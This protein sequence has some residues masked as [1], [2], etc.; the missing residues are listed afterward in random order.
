MTDPRTP[1]LDL[2]NCD[3]EPIQ[4]LGHV[5]PYGCLIAVSSDWNVLHASANTGAML[6]L[7][8]EAIIGSR[9]IDLLPHEVVH[10]LRGR[11]QVLGQDA[12]G[13]RIYGVDLFEDGRRFDVSVHQTDRCYLFEF[14][15]KMPQPHRDEMSLVAPLMARVRRKTDITGMAREAARAMKMLSGFDRVMVYRFEPDDS[16]TVIAEAKEAGMQPYM[17]LRFPAS[18]IPP[19]ARALYTRNLLRLIMDVDA[20]PQ[21]ILPPL[22]PAGKP[23]DLSMSVTRAVSPIHLQYLRNMGVAASMSV[24]ILREGRLWG[25]FACHHDTPRYI[26]Y[27]KRSAVELFAQLFAYE[28][29]A[30]ESGAERAQVARAR[31]LHELLSSQMVGSDAISE[32]FDTI[33]E[34]IA[35][36]IPFDGLAMW[37]SGRYHRAG[38]T[39]TPEEFDGLLKHLNTTDAGRVYTTERLSDGYRGAAAIADRVAGIMALP[40]SRGARDYIVLF[41]RELRQ[42]VTW[43]GDPAKPAEMGPNGLQLS[44]RTSFKAWQQEVRNQSAPWTDAEI[45]AAET[46]RVTLIEVVLRI[47]GDTDASRQRAQERQELLIA[48]LNHRVRN[49]LNLIRGLVSQ[50]RA[51]ATTISDY[52]EILDGR[53]NALARAHDQL[54]RNDR[55]SSSLIE[56]IDTEMTAFLAADRDRVRVSGD[57]VLLDP[58]AF[59]TLALVLHELMTNAA[60]YGALVD[61]HG[62]V[63]LTLTRTNDAALRID[64]REHG[65]APVTAPKGRGFG[66]TVIERSIPFELQGEAELRFAETG[67]EASFRVPARYISTAPV[68]KPASSA[69]AAQPVLPAQPL[70]GRA[71]VVEDNMIIALDATDILTELG[72]DTVSTA[73]RVADALRLIEAQA[74]DFAL[75]DVNLGAETSAPVAKALRARGVPFVLA[76]GYGAGDG[77]AKAFPG[78]PVLNKPYTKQAVQAQ[79]NALL[80]GGTGGAAAASPRT[81]DTA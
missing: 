46:L 73:S 23:L 57:D 21:P 22:D 10:H 60:K 27:E 39:P 48:E 32:S 71:L 56:L 54:T 12:G 26:D 68:R 45:A 76:T 75:V 70:S 5:Q 17:G 9:L 55:E 3:V 30:V 1:P 7:E 81:G 80:H 59:S 65:S 24:S 28:I 42:Q 36:V 49:I 72:A 34:E 6:G 25:L 4:F 51:G 61:S 77:L 19:Q 43:A 29:A 13:A 53:I 20:K 44:P 69:A 8:A 63:D 79:F 78:A 37:I 52:T 40:V 74:F 33:A 11:I 35:D 38:V 50:G 58:D 66:T 16:G 47:A 41:R 14:E 67:V 31:Q 2:T 18:D 15:P 64:W 62:S